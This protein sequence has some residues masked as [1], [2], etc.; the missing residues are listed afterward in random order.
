MH[1]KLENSIKDFIKNNALQFEI[2]NR[3]SNSCILAGY[4]CYIGCNSEDITDILKLMD[5]LLDNE[6][7]ERDD[8]FINV[9]NYALNNNYGKW[10]DNPAAKK[11]YNF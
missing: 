10:W 6:D 9:F 5:R 2:G 1:I 7:N 11:M 4:A 8:E 3:N